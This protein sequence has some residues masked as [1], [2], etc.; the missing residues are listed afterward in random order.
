MRRLLTAAGFILGAGLC[1]GSSCLNPCQQLAQKICSCEPTTAEQQAC[2]RQAQLQQDQRTLTNEDRL[3]CQQ[4]LVNCEC[5][6][7][8]EGKLEVCGLSR[9]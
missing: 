5:R 7:L 1:M 2:T 4:T 3:Y 9:E 8:K 6:A